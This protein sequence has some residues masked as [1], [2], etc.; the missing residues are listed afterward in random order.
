MGVRVECWRVE[1]GRVEEVVVEEGK[2]EGVEVAAR[3]IGRLY[4]AFA[5]ARGQEGER[6][7]GVGPEEGVEHWYP[8]FEYALKRHEL[9]EE[10]Y[11]DNGFV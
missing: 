7:V 9:I 5:D 11:R 8:D 1:E 2:W 4:E 10:M 3:N 6:E